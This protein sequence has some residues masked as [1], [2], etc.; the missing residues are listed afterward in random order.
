[1]QN[2]VVLS[3]VVAALA[4]SPALAHVTLEQSEAVVDRPAKLTFRVPHGCGSSPT[5]KLKVYIPEGVVAVKP[6]VKPGWT[7]ET[8]EGDYAQTH[9]FFHGVKLSRGVKQITWS[10]SLPDR[11][12]DEFT[13]NV[14]VSNLLKPGTPL[15]FPVEQECESGT[16]KWVEVPKGKASAHDLK[17]PAPALTLR[18]A[19]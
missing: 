12:Y 13:I 8:V 5:V 1:M 14:F 10:G 2:I 4:A 11:F 6:M 18:R 16:H 3:V 7:I 9:N 19:K 15:Y 17:E